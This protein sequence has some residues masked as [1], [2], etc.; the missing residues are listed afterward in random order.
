MIF[1]EKTECATLYNEK[2]INHAG[3]GKG[4]ISERDPPLSL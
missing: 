3:I 1:Y 2:I 4:R